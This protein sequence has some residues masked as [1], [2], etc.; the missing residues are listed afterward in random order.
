M[1]GGNV[2]NVLWKSNHHAHIKSQ[3]LSL[4]LYPTAIEKCFFAFAFRFLIICQPQYA[5]RCWNFL[6]FTF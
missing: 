4:L 5:R 1:R 3:G 2:E 6:P